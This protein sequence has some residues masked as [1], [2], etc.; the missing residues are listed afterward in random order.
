MFCQ[1]LCLPIVYLISQGESWL[2][3]P[4]P[5]LFINNSF[6]NIL[7]TRSRGTL[8]GGTRASRDKQEVRTEGALE[9]ARSEYLETNDPSPPRAALCKPIHHLSIAGVIVPAPQRGGVI[10]AFYHTEGQ[11]NCHLH[12]T[13][14]FHVGMTSL[15]P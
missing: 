14:R 9:V 3:P 5:R 7:I 6:I 11:L 2:S 13:W 1:R 8:Q 10:S 4:V 12:N 15:C